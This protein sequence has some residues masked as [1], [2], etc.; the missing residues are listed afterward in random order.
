MEREFFVIL[1]SN[2]LPNQ[3]IG[4]YRVDLPTPLHLEGSWQVAIVQLNYTNSIENLSPLSA[5]DLS[6]IVHYA[7]EDVFLMIT[8]P[9]GYYH[10]AQAL[11][12]TINSELQRAGKIC[13]WLI[14]ESP[15]NYR[16]LIE[17]G[18]TINLSSLKVPHEVVNTPAAGRDMIG[19]AMRFEFDERVQKVK[20]V[21][22]PD[23][24]FGSVHLGPLL[25]YM[26]G[27]SNQKIDRKDGIEITAKY[28]FDL[29]GGQSILYV[30]SNF[31]Q[32]Q[33]V[34]GQTV[35]LLGYFPHDINSLKFG[36]MVQ[37]RPNILDFVN[38]TSKSLYSISIEVKNDNDRLVPFMFGKFII[39]LLFRK[40]RPPTVM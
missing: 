13:Y 2:S 3:L 21:F 38:V 29:S 27:F 39:K 26:M 12:E 1:P 28:A 36:Q 25:R 23:S 11:L 7:P 16:D 20:I 8:I 30:Y 10:S 19:S 14:K 18:A 33:M 32:S 9:R 37:I 34:G 15:K 35:P 40:C 5:A 6:I 22:H 24:L 17:A 4:Q 31:V